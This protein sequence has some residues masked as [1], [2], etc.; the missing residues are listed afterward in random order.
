MNETTQPAV[1]G[2]VE[3]TVRP[4]VAWVTEGGCEVLQAG[5][6]PARAMPMQDEE[7]GFTVPLYSSAALRGL[8]DALQRINDWCCY[9]TEEDVNARLLA[10]QQIGQT[11][12]EAL[13]TLQ[14]EPNECRHPDCACE[15]KVCGPAA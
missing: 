11:A 2:P 13:A 12:R 8:K 10:L 6:G 9:A 3:P 7:T 1:A 15:S 5:D 4:L 14:P